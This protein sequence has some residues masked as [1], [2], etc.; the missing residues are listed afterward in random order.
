MKAVLSQRIQELASIDGV[1]GFEQR[2]VAYMAEAFGAMG[3]PTELDRFGN[4][5][6][7]KRGLRGS[8]T[9]MVAAHSDE[10]GAIVKSVDP[11]GFLRFEKLGGTQDQLLLGR[12]VSV[13]G[14]FGVVGVKAG[15]LQKGG[16]E[17]PRASEMYVDVGAS[18][19]EG[20]AA[21]GIGVGD[22]IAYRSEVHPF[23]NPDRLC[24]K[25]IDNRVGCAM[26]LQLFEEL[27][28]VDFPGTI[29]GVVNSQEEVGWRG[30]QLVGRRLQPDAALVVDTIPS[31]DTPDTDFHRELA[32]AIGAGPVI[33]LMSGGF[34]NGYLMTPAMKDL[35][36]RLAREEG[37]PH[38]P[39]L[40][41]GS[42]SDAIT[43]HM[44]GEGI[45]TGIVNIPRRYAHSPV[46]VLDLND[47]VHAQRLLRRATVAL[48]T[49][50]IGWT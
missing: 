49:E 22:P 19:P 16:A 21:L 35:L 41:P 39:A 3:V 10:I 18:S 46:E 6:A 37:I 17:L 29:Y 33:A 27:Q 34:P 13:K 14:V 7:T 8:P 4:L 26:L 1:A 15:H 38:Q 28:G 48:A 5:I 11:R 42:G 23:S 50:P 24:G 36:L 2:V 20:V 43:L 32:I 31:G 47:V 9:V 25:A 30:I 40:F 12:Q 45:P 44:V